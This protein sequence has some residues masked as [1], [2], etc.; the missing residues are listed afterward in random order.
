MLWDNALT[1]GLKFELYLKTA[2]TLLRQAATLQANPVR[3]NATFA[4]PLLVC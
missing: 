1:I 4:S 2:M 3:V